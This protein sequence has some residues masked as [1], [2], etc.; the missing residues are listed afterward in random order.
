VTI[1]LARGLDVPTLSSRDQGWWQARRWRSVHT[2]GMAEKARLPVPAAPML[3]TLGGP[4]T[5]GAGFAF[6]LKWDGS[7]RVRGFLRVVVQ[8]PARGDSPW[9]VLG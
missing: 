9:I 6:E 5:V 1:R 4:P 8:E 7:K 3:A 2:S